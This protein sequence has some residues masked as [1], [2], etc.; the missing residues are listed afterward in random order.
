MIAGVTAEE[1]AAA[2]GIAGAVGAG[3]DLDGV[4]AEAAAVAA[5]GIGVRTDRAGAAICL[6]RSMPLRRVL[7]K[8][9]AD[10]TIGLRTIAAPSLPSKSVRTTL[11]CRANR[12]PNIARALCPLRSN[13]S[14]ITNPRSV[15]PT[16]SRPPRVRRLA[17]NPVRERPGVSPAA[18]RI[19][20]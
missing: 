16:M 10:L 9:V 3:D 20:F 1:I 11:C 5:T 6:P 12:S 8:I 13:L 18:C 19:G 17:C 4:A 15:N 14:V 2:T 7:V